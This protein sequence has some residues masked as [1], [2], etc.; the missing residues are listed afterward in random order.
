MR[1]IAKEAGY[2]PGAIYGYFASKQLILSD[3]LDSVLESLTAAVAQRVTPKVAPEQALC[4]RGQAWISYLM[5]HPFDKQLL[6]HLYRADRSDKQGQGSSLRIHERVLGTLEPLSQSVPLDSLDPE[7]AASELEAIWAHA[8]GLLLSSEADAA[9]NSVVAVSE[10]FTNYL[11]RLSNSLVGANLV[12][13]TA[14]ENSAT[15]LDMFA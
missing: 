5:E 6:L 11:T 3:L 10:R 13:P 4:A 7:M 2:T 8:L 9:A 1:E 15:Q 14:Q 12:Q